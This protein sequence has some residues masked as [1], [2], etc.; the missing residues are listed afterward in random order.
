MPRR[1]DRAERNRRLSYYNFD[2]EAPAFVD[3]H[4]VRAPRSV[5][6]R[7]VRRGEPF[8][9]EGRTCW[10]DG[11]PRNPWVKRGMTYALLDV[12]TQAQRPPV[13]CISCGEQAV[14]GRF[15]PTCFP[16]RREILALLRK[17]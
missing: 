3:S 8:E 6:D 13:G 16:H 5:L 7:W 4:T 17:D 11:E 9:L 15:C 2:D 10:P 12:R 1:Y 14:M